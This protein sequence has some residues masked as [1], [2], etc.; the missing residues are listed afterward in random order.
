MRECL[1]SGSRSR[2]LGKRGQMRSYGQ[3]NGLHTILKRRISK[4]PF[5]PRSVSERRD[6][7]TDNA[8]R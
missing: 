6:I 4:Y 3:D 5:V 7:E 1:I 2:P 8:I